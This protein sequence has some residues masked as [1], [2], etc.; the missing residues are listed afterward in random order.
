MSQTLKQMR[1]PP[2]EDLNK[3]NAEMEEMQNN[4]RE[5]VNAKADIQN[6]TEMT[7]EKVKF[8]NKLIRALAGE[9]TRWMACAGDFQLRLAALPGNAMNCCFDTLPV[10]LASSR[11]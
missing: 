10:W 1:I 7:K 4:L 9:K 6:E 8:A 3:T 11:S 2:E 5:A